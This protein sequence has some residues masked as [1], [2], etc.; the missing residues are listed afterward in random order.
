MTPGNP[1]WTLSGQESTERDHADERAEYVSAFG[2]RI[3]LV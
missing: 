1:D 2:S 3:G